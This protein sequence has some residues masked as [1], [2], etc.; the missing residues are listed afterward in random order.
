M[1]II[2]SDVFEAMQGFAHERHPNEI[3][4]LLRGEKTGDDFHITDFLHPPFGS[5]SKKFASFPS[6]LLP[7]DFTIIGTA[8]SHPSGNLKPSTGDL[9]NFY[10]YIMMIIGPPYDKLK[11]AAYSKNGEKIEL[12]ILN[13]QQ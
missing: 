11:A 7:I 5:G 12:R 4:L 13:H 8:H 3:I 1:I 10:G 6:N 9:H 2:K